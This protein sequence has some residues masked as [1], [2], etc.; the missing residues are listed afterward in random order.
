MKFEFKIGYTLKPFTKEELLEFEKDFGEL[1]FNF[2]LEIYQ[3]YYEASKNNSY[4]EICIEKKTNEVR[5]IVISANYLILTW[6]PFAH[7][8]TFF[9]LVTEKTDN[10]FLLLRE[11]IT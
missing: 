4:F 8:T 1:N 11:K 6:V 9:F 10:L 5:V 3:L 2:L 7:S